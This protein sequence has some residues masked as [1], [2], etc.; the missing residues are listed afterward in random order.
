MCRFATVPQLS[1]SKFK[2]IL[3][4][5][6]CFLRM[7]IMKPHILDVTPRNV[8]I[9]SKHCRVFSMSM[10][11][12]RPPQS[13]A[14]FTSQPIARRSPES[15]QQSLEELAQTLAGEIRL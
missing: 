8:R 14:Y 5:R 13:G 6:R 15:S 3:T 2:L 7:Y 11:T 1:C 9:P 12:Q 4:V 10:S